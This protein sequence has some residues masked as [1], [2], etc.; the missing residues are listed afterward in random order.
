M[1]FLVT[2]QYWIVAAGN[3]QLEYGAKIPKCLAGSQDLILYIKVCNQTNV[4]RHKKFCLEKKIRKE[5]LYGSSWCPGVSC[6]A[7]F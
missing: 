5:V 4:Y 6:Y 7:T 2:T 1:L 3:A